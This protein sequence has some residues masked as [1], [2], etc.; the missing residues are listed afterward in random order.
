LAVGIPVI[1][2]WG[3]FLASLLYELKPADPGTLV[4]AGLLLSAVA[5]LAGWVPARRAS[6]IAPMEA[7]W[8]D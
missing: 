2:V 1:L 6:R 3:R 7:L 8:H 4:M 5:V